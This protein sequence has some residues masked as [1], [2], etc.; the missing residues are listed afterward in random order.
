MLFL[1]R[2]RLSRKV[3]H[4]KLMAP[5]APLSEKILDIVGAHRRVTVR[6][7]AAITGANRNTIKNHIAGRMWGDWCSG[8]EVGEP[9]MKREADHW[10]REPTRISWTST[11][12]T[13]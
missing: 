11:T 10:P 2:E 1:N 7:A 9:G 4:E 12:H 3:T 6:D 5:M 13:S 8:D